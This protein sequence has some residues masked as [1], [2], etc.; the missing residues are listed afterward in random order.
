MISIWRT[1]S[2]CLIL[3]AWSRKTN[4]VAYSGSYL[5]ATPGGSTLCQF[6]TM[7]KWYSDR[8]S[9][10]LPSITMCWTP[11]SR[12]NFRYKSVRCLL[13]LLAELPVTTGFIPAP[14]PRAS[15][16]MPCRGGTADGLRRAT[17][18][19]TSRTEALGQREDLPFKEKSGS[20]R[21]VGVDPSCHIVTVGSQGLSHDEHEV[22]K[23]IT[24][25]V[26]PPTVPP[27]QRSSNVPRMR[28]LESGSSTK[29]AGPERAATPTGA[30]RA[31]W[32]RPELP[33][34]AQNSPESH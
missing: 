19:V 23:T 3:P 12:Q 24:T 20:I 31:F 2:T 1:V 26:S 27:G 16:A 11:S 21:V 8:C 25:I 29:S 17:S 10:F 32:V 14:A 7:I 28:L 4:Q 34:T 6:W 33:E 13:G 9:R 5:V 22:W 18:L 15:S 30:P